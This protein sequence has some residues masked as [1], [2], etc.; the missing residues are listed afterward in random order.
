MTI[1]K[2]MLI[3]ELIQ[4]DELVAPMLM[5]AGMHCLGCPASQGESLEEACMVHGIDC[6]ELV[7]GMNEVL[8]SR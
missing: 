6:D 3:G 1:D 8:A 5:R 7:A 4:M 2:S